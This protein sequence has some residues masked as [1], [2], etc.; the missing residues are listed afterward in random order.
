M[1]QQD[2]GEPEVPRRLQG[3]T[4]QQ[5]DEPRLLPNS[6]YSSGTARWPVWRSANFRGVRKTHQPAHERGALYK[7][8]RQARYLDHHLQQGRAK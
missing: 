3:E 5:M 8:T 7:Y 1:V 6:L 2:A 4:E